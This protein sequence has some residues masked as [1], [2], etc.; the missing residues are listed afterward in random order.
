MDVVFIMAVL[1]YLFVGITVVRR[2]GESKRKKVKKIN[3][4]FHRL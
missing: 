1:T 4:F 3:R 2:K